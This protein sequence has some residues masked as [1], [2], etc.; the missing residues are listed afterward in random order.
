M[1]EEPSSRTP[2]EIA[3]DVARTLAETKKIEAETKK[4]EAEALVEEIN[5]RAEFRKR[6]REKASDEE[7]YL[8]R[9]AGEVSKN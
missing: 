5:A 4:A 6:E 1:S 8:Y 2:E 9:F 3:A 7:N